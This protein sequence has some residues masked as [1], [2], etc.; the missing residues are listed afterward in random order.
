MEPVWHEVLRLKIPAIPA[1]KPRPRSTVRAGRAVVYDVRKVNK[2]DGRKVDHPSVTFA[3]TVRHAVCQ[4]YHGPPI[5]GALRLDLTFVLPR[6]KSLIWKTKPM[7][8]V[9]H[10]SKPD[11]DNLDKCVMDALTG[12]LWRDDCQVAGGELWKWIASGYEQP[13]VEMRLYRT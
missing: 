8:R 9:L 4:L 7:P 1:G 12:L 11:R 13:H 6:P 3:A 2:S 5:E 10:T